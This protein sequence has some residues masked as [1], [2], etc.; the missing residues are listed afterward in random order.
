M[1][2]QIKRRYVSWIDCYGKRHTKH[3]ADGVCQMCGEAEG[4]Q[5][6]DKIRCSDCFDKIVK[7]V[8]REHAKGPR[9][10][11]DGKTEK[12]I[13]EQF[14]EAVRCPGCKC[15]V[16]TVLRL[17]SMRPDEESLCANCFFDAAFSEDWNVR[18]EVRP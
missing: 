3:E 6:G 5:I 4:I 1:P 11:G 12:V 14:I 7:E 15:K 16:N 17:P 2:E 18:V 8:E 9:L 10:N 13:A